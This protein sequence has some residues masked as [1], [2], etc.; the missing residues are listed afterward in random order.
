MNPFRHGI[1]M[2]VAATNV[3]VVPCHLDGTFDAMPPGAKWPR[4]RRIVLRI[5][6]P[7]RFEGVPNERAGWQTVTQTLERA[8]R[9][10]RTKN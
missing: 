7:C 8:V 4:L 5:G 6:L 3:L 2:I 1:G 10:L 9:A